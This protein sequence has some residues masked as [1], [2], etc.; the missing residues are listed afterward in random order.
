MILFDFL[1]RNFSFYV[2]SEVYERTMY[3]F[4]TFINSIFN[5]IQMKSHL[6]HADSTDPLLTQQNIS[7]KRTFI[8]GRKQRAPEWLH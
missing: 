3:I 1:F 6:D 5:C 4:L 8:N 7:E 2:F